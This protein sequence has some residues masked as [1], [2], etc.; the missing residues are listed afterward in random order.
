MPAKFDFLS[1]GVLLR[2]VDQSQIPAP[3]TEDGI[4]IIGTAP[5]GPAMKPVRV[6]DLDSFLQ[7]FGN[8]T[9]GRQASDVWRNPSFGPSYG[10]YAA[11][12]WL[13]S[14]ASPVTFVRL[15]GEESGSQSSGLRAGWTTTDDIDTSLADNGGA[16]GLWIHASQSTTALVPG[17]GTLAAIIYADQGGLRLKGKIHLPSLTDTAIA[18]YMGLGQNSTSSL[19]EPILSLGTNGVPGEF[20]IEHVS[21]DGSATTSYTV[22]FGASAQ[23]G[24]QIRSV[25]P[26]NAAKTNS[27]IFSSTNE[28]FLGETFEEAVDRAINSF[29][30]G[31]S[32]AKEEQFGVLIHL[33]KADDSDGYAKWE[34]HQRQATAAKSGWFISQDTGAASSFA[35]NSMQRL[36]R[37]VGLSDGEWIHKYQIGIE[38]Q[39]L[40]NS[41]NPYSTFSL[42]LMDRQENKIE[43]FKN[44]NFNPGSENYIAKRI[45]DQYQE[46]DEGQKKYRVQGE[47]ANQSDYIY[48]E[49]SEAVKNGSLDSLSAVPFGVQGP[50]TFGDFFVGNN[51]NSKTGPVREA[52]GTTD[53]N[54]AAS[55]A[56]E[57]DEVIYGS[58]TSAANYVGT[59]G[60]GFHHGG[61]HARFSWPKLRL[62]TQNGSGSSGTNYSK[63]DFL[64]IDH[65]K[66]GSTSMDDSYYDL[67][68]A[69]SKTAGGQSHEVHTTEFTSPDA[70]KDKIYSY[71]FSLDDVVY[72]SSS[73][74]V[75]WDGG[76]GDANQGALD[77]TVGS[78]KGGTS[79]TA[80]NGTDALVNTLRV[81]KFK[82]PLFGG[83]DGVNIKEANPF[84]NHAGA[85]GH[86]TN[87][88][89][90][91]NYTLH[92]V[93]K[94]LDTVSDPEIVSYDIISIPGVTNTKITDKVLEIASSRGDSL[95]V[96]DLQSG[97][98]PANV[99]AT[100]NQAGSVKAT[101]DHAVGRNFDTSYGACYYPWI[102]LRD[103][104]GG[105]ND[106]IM[107]PPSVAAIGAL[108]RS[109]AVSEPWFA[110]AGF[111]RGGIRQLGGP[112]GPQCVGTWEHLT[113]DNRD[114]LYAENIN[115]IAR[116]PAIN[117]IVIFGQ[118]TL[119]QT[120]S[121][122]DRINVRR[123][124]IF[125]KKAIGR[126]ADTILFDQN[127]NTTWLR[128]KNE[129]DQVL[130]SV[131]T[132]LGVTE[133]KIVL[134]K[135]TTTA[136]YIDRNILYA[137]IFVKP[138]RA[139]EFIV[140]DFVIT[141]T[142]VE[143]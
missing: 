106:V 38:I 131:Q 77:G 141:R 83:F 94:A 78:R 111:N 64:G 116:F 24:S 72:D 132:R 42:Y 114:D 15:L 53:Y 92:S 117:E 96:I 100:S 124:M 119:Q 35:P 17:T 107:A 97:F 19:G 3:T 80:L 44:L 134:D 121:A 61:H 6:R 122:L 71:F 39:R 40:G 29:N 10:M 7:V 108:A 18:T 105:N 68:R 27:T 123:L 87:T 60:W 32:K 23:S 54:F 128:F 43:Q 14:E 99:E 133:Y 8:P 90:I 69:G 34:N 95:G 26:T 41:V 30:G 81:R 62:T 2:E 57:S 67:V 126:I 74:T 4:L 59:D 28:L 102:R 75:Y 33:G 56:E 73:D 112:L 104:I 89:E 135:S 130:G 1:P 49:L 45:G 137:K 36:F 25:I 79:Y 118:K 9:T 11:Q 98:Q 113:K 31:S 140:V 84:A 66:S 55:F 115:P 129:A 86:P 127:V 21:S 58:N 76:D 20:E 138:A 103:T 51:L 5:Q 12:A 143:F 91:T 63:S 136:D 37:I 101:I 88:T 46:W 48:V 13:S 109:E 22:N 85:L 110:P 93:M 70:T 120:P 125:L 139:I 65:H 47:Y 142:G 16:Y 50:I 82:S 52:G